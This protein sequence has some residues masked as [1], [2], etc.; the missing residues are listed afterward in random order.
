MEYRTNHEELL[1]C[2]GKQTGSFLSYD[3]L[4]GYRRSVLRKSPKHIVLANTCYAK[5]VNRTRNKARNF[6]LAF[7]WRAFFG[8]KTISFIVSFPNL[9]LVVRNM[10]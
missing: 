8:P 4:W 7:A 6:H 9:Y 10:L 2:K 5:P 1:V 3:P